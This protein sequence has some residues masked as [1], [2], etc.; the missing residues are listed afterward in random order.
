MMQARYGPRL[1][2]F[3]KADPARRRWPRDATATVDVVEDLVD[4][5]LLAACEFVVGTAHSS[6]SRVAALLNG[7]PRCVALSEAAEGWPVRAA[8]RLPYRIRRR[9]LKAAPGGPPRTPLP[10]FGLRPGA[11]EQ[12]QARLGTPDAEFHRAFARGLAEANALLEAAPVSVLDKGQP[13][14]SGDPHDYFSIAPYFWPD[15]A[16]PGG[17]PYTRQD[18][19]INPESA[20]AANDKARLQTMSHTLLTLGLAFRLTGMEAYARQA[21]RQLR[22]WFLDPATRMNPHLDYAQVVPGLAGGRS[23]GVIEGQYLLAAL[24]AAGMLRG[25]DGWPAEEQAGLAAWM[26]AYLRWLQTSRNARKEGASQNNHGTYYDLQVMHLALFLDDLGLARRTARAVKRRRI[27]A[28]I[29]PD[30]TQPHE[31]ARGEALHYSMYNLGALCHLAVRAEH[32]GDDLWRYRPPGGGGLRAALDY[33]VP[34]LDPAGQPWPHG[35][36]RHAE[37][38]PLVLR[39]AA[40]VYAEPRYAQL[41][42]SLGL[43]A[44]PQLLDVVLRA[45]SAVAE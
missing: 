39:L 3:P 23:Y 19:R 4:L 20:G 5:W 36:T 44:A 38:F 12:A 32:L 13:G 14:P 17:L 24:D 10:V 16:R 35:G 25:T 37:G 1:I 34:Y 21:A 40:A 11:L 9:L 28:Q 26:R 33:L 7:S 30:G 43:A 15:P 41:L 18:G 6:F 31:L 27:A 45:A 42:A 22:T 29:L 8:Q 2:H